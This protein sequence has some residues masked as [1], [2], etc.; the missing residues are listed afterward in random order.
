MYAIIFSDMI[1][2][3]SKNFLQFF[4]QR[5]ERYRLES[6]DNRE[7]TSNNCTSSTVDQTDKCVEDRKSMRGL[8]MERFLMKGDEILK[9][10]KYQK[11]LLSLSESDSDSDDGHNRSSGSIAKKLSAIDGKTRQDIG[12]LLSD[13]SDDENSEGDKVYAIDALS[14]EWI[15]HRRPFSPSKC[16]MQPGL[17]ESNL[18]GSWKRAGRRLIKQSM[19]VGQRMKKRNRNPGGV[20]VC[21]LKDGDDATVRLLGG[22]SDS[23]DDGNEGLEDELL[24]NS[25]MGS[26]TDTSTNLVIR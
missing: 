3:R 18:A 26:S 7:A 16:F 9:S 11:F 25:S 4:L 21:H 12:I 1:K 19:T 13:S 2:S 10:P 24:L 20:K 6:G 5:F 17:E 23:E 14:G 8:D 15:P 22:D